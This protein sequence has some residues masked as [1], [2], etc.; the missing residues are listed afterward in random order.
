MNKVPA[1]LLPYPHHKDEHQKFNAVPLSACDGA[2][3]CKDWIDANLN[4]EHNGGTLETL[5]ADPA[6]RG[7]MRANLEKLGPAD[8]ATRIARALLDAL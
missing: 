5:L 7:V 2:V 4:L 8:G 1:L 6:R 3:V